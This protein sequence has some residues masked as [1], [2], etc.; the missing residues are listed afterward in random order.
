MNG[1]NKNVPETAKPVYMPKKI[2]K[3]TNSALSVVQCI[4][5]YAVVPFEPQ[6]AHVV[7]TLQ[8][9]MCISRMPYYANNNQQVTNEP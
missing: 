3:C 9:S 4:L 1:R 8:E 6:V 2:V 5:I 7:R